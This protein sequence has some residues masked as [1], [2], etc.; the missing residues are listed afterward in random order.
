MLLNDFLNHYFNNFHY[1]I[2]HSYIHINIIM[3]LNFH[4][5]HIYLELLYFI[6]FL[7]FINDINLI[8]FQ[9]VKFHLNLFQN[10]II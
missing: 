9:I 6:D 5:I 8:L 2:L 7:F 3:N 1:N 4:N 10:S